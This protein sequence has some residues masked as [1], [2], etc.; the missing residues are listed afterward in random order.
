MK[1]Q[2]F[3]QG[4]ILC[5]SKPEEVELELKADLQN[6]NKY[7]TIQVTPTSMEG[8]VTPY[9]VLIGQ[10]WAFG[11]TPDKLTYFMR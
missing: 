4:E 11:N 7:T 5:L 6:E 2:H 8:E 9:R 10:L 3:L 1:Y